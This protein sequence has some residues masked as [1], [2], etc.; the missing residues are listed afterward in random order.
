[1]IEMAGSATDKGQENKGQENEPQAEIIWTSVL[2][3]ATT[4]KGGQGNYRVPG[5]KEGGIY[6][7]TASF[8]AYSQPGMVRVVV[9]AL[10][11]AEQQEVIAAR[12][13]A[14]EAQLRGGGN[15]RSNGSGS[16]RA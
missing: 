4:T 3:L 9:L 13:A 2:Q 15:H 16:G 1:M 5:E 11:E 10:S 6:L 8:E 14:F 7:P 12:V